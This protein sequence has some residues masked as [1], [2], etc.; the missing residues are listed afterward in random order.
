MTI[1]KL[2]KIGTSYGLI[3]DASIQKL[4]GVDETKQ[5]VI[6]VENKKVIIT[7]YNE[8]YKQKDKSFDLIL[9]KLKK[10]KAIE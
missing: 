1:K 10:Y 5:V 9:E 4:I 7:A 2:Q 3:L 8:E 6:E